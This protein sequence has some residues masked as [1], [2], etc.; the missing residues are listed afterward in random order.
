MNHTPHTTSELDQPIRIGIIGS[1]QVAAGLAHLTASTGCAVTLLADEQ[2]AETTR[3]L[4]MAELA[5]RLAHGQVREADV[6]KTLDRI[7]FTAHFA[8]LA[9]SQFVFDLRLVPQNLTEET[10]HRIV[11]LD[12]VIGG[13]D[14]TIL[15]DP[16][17]HG[18]SDLAAV[19]AR[20]ERILGVRLLAPALTMPLMELIPGPQTDPEVVVKAATLATAVLEKHVI[21]SMNHSLFRDDARP[22]PYVLSAIQLAESRLSSA[23]D[24]DAAQIPGCTKPLGPLEFADL[25]GLDVLKDILERLHR[26]G[27][28]AAVHVPESL[29][30]LVDRGHL[31]RK[32]GRGYH[33]YPPPQHDLLVLPAG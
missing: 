7:R 1:G 14:A 20:P 22:V 21:S 10:L 3:G 31:G 27:A 29:H 12:A 2:A 28:G 23:E 15:I 8:D 33:R 32:T 17:T 30:R 16:G 11:E 26:T 6:P 19:A 5:Q 25:L 18:V 4:V 24:V 13:P 9:D